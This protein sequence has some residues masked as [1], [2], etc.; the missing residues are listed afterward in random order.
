MCKGLDNEVEIC[1]ESAVVSSGA[2]SRM[3]TRK[4]W[5]KL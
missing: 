2:A 4:K 5:F 1:V 3:E